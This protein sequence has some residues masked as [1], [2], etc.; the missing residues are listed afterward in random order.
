MNKIEEER[1]NFCLVSVVD[2]AIAT[3]NVF[4]KLVDSCLFIIVY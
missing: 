4:N 2:V 1:N 3:F